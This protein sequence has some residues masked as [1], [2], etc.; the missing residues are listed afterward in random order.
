MK[1]TYKKRKNSKK[2]T[3]TI[4]RNRHTG[5]IRQ[6]KGGARNLRDVEFGI[7][8]HQTM[9]DCIKELI[10]ASFSIY[11]QL[12][13]EDGPITIVC[14][15]QS[16]SYYCLAMMNFKMYNPALVNIVILPHTK[17]G[18]RA[19]NQLTE[20]IAYCSQLRKKRN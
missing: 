16:P 17:E 5:R 3:K 7:I 18:K 13:R 8:T 2:I 4:R 20:N 12:L 19:E 6:M 9:G 11:A 1:K 10:E 14:G 15:G